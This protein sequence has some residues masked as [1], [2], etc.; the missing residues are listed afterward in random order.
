MATLTRV[1]CCFLMAVV[2][3]SFNSLIAHPESSGNTYIIPKM[4]E[5]IVYEG[6]KVS[7]CF[8]I[9]YPAG[10]TFGGPIS[11]SGTIEN[12]AGIFKKSQVDFQ[13]D[14]NNPCV[15]LKVVAFDR[16][17][18]QA[19]VFDV[20]SAK[21]KVVVQSNV[22]IIVRPIPDHRQI[23]FKNDIYIK[24][25]DT[26]IDGD[27]SDRVILANT[28]AIAPF[29][30][31]TMAAYDNS[32]I[33]AQYSSAYNM[34]YTGPDTL[35]EN[36]IM[37]I[38]IGDKE[39]QTYGNIPG[40]E[41]FFNGQDYSENFAVTNASP[42]I[43]DSG[44]FLDPNNGPFILSL[45]QG[46]F[47]ENSA[48]QINF[49]GNELFNF[50]STNLGDFSS[51][52]DPV[53][54]VNFGTG[55]DF[56]VIL[57]CDGYLYLCDLQEL[58]GDSGSWGFDAGGAGVDNFDDQT[59]IDFCDIAEPDCEEV[60]SDFSVD[61]CSLSLSIANCSILDDADV[62]LFYKASGP[63]EDETG[64]QQIGEGDIKI[65][66]TSPTTANIVAPV[67]HNVG[68]YMI[69]VICEECNLPI[70]HYLEVDE[71]CPF[72]YSTDIQ[73][74]SCNPTGGVDLEIIGVGT[75]P[76]SFEW[77]NGDTNQNLSMVDAGLYTVTVTDANQCTAII[78]AD[79][80]S[81]CCEYYLD[82]GGP[83]LEVAD[84][85][86]DG[87]WLSTN[88]NFSFP[89][90]FGG[91]NPQNITITDLLVDLSIY[92]AGS[93]GSISVQ[94][95]AIIIESCR[96]YQYIVG[97]NNP[98]KTLPC[99]NT[100]VV[101]ISNSCDI[102]VDPE[103]AVEFD[104]ISN[105]DC[106]IDVLIY[107]LQN[108]SVTLD[109]SEIGTG[110]WTAV[111]ADLTYSTQLNYAASGL[112]RL[113]G[114]GDSGCASVIGCEIEHICCECS[115]TSVSFTGDY[116]DDGEICLGID[117]VS[118]AV[119]TL[120]CIGES[121]V[122]AELPDGS[123]VTLDQ[124]ANNQYEYVDTIINDEYTGLYSFEV[125]D[126]YGCF[127]EETYNLEAENCT[128][129]NNCEMTMV[130][131]SPSPGLLSV[132][133]LY[134]GC[135]MMDSF[136]ISWYH[137]TISVD[138]KILEMGTSSDNLP[139]PL[140]NYPVPSGTMI[141]VLDWIS[142]DGV[143][144]DEVYPGI[145]DC[146]DAVQVEMPNCGQ[147]YTLS[148]NYTTTDNA[149]VAFDYNIAGE[150]NYILLTFFGY[151]INDTI[152]VS[153]NGTSVFY[154]AVGSDASPTDLNSTPKTIRLSS[155]RFMISKDSLDTDMDSLL[156]VQ[157]ISSKLNAN[158]N[159]QLIIQ[160]TDDYECG[161]IGTLDVD[162]IA[163]DY[164]SINC[165]YIVQLPRY[166]VLNPSGLPERTVR[167]S[168]PTLVVSNMLCGLQI[169]AVYDAG[170]PNCEDEITASADPAAGRFTLDFE[171]N[172]SRYTVLKDAI[173]DSI[174]SMDINC[175]SYENEEYYSYLRFSVFALSSYCNP[176]TGDGSSLSYTKNI[177]IRPCLAN[178]E[179][180]D[181]EM[182]I[183][184]IR[185]PIL[186]YQE[187]ACADCR[188]FIQSNLINYINSQIP[189]VPEWIENLHV[190]VSSGNFMF[191]D[192][193]SL[194]NMVF[195]SQFIRHTYQA[196]EICD[197]NCMQDA[198]KLVI[199]DMADG[200]NNYSLYQSTDP[201]AGL[202]DYDQLIY[203]VSNG[204]QTYAANED[205]EDYFSE[206]DLTDI[207]ENEVKDM[208]MQLH[209]NPASTVV[210]LD[211]HVSR[212]G[213]SIMTIYDS[214][215]RVV[216]QINY[217]SNAGSNREKIDIS[218]LNSGL[219][220]VKLQHGTLSMYKK[221]IVIK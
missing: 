196:A 15:E 218:D 93:G 38:V 115:I 113:S 186:N 89:Y 164:D 116:L 158:T 112:Y 87:L 217:R 106:S 118:F 75:P 86:V 160:C 121:V 42:N 102:V 64:Y 37:C 166:G 32:S 14:V 103:C 140:Y 153:H 48:G 84:I 69:E 119:T 213:T 22:T 7:V 150:S 165:R 85:K 91:N 147:Y 215:L 51:P 216:D 39:V 174:F 126:E 43:P 187:S 26:S 100:D 47:Y 41:L 44:S 98:G 96:N 220:F 176:S 50:G 161:S 206:K 179:F 141:P 111:L 132:A 95:S 83:G 18:P 40:V 198:Y 191:L 65:I 136:Q 178:F 27:G 10:S 146:F 151:T 133:N 81:C 25:L 31:F 127:G 19:F 148:Y 58:L 125:V 199:D 97:T 190:N 92:E 66:K 21:P 144:Y 30:S 3:L 182:T 6:S 8:D 122:T 129:C 2:G 123:Q 12:S 128:L 29:T 28:T 104:I 34:M 157:V 189:T 70:V 79:I 20:Q 162:E 72:S 204:I 167:R 171:D 99:E 155:Y 45:G 197:P 17:E 152:K 180:D 203:Q 49:S 33:V 62:T 205:V 124:V 173:I 4:R 142:I 149:D 143:F 110:V 138:S 210:N 76:F 168:V 181:V 107:E 56:N 88:S 52:T 11:L 105:D 90:D 1:W 131:Y 57:I 208:D 108:Y 194:S 184:L 185:I 68:C 202:N 82:F 54:D 169:Q 137:D 101:T 63:C 170:V 109:Y 24:G 53:P 134:S 175:E 159:W 35:P 130:A 200:C 192:S 207:L 71:C 23:L 80:E 46:Q 154:A 74:A 114:I 145:G 135:G 117:S 59:C 183:T 188:T 16:E 77:N 209:P 177:Y 120:G 73:D 201:C 36:G 9:E 139:M 78:S 195:G 214:D 60:L 67:Y 211:Y 193:T 172:P 94:G 61:G 212:Q 55:G 5:V 163:C 156:H 13:I 219:Y 221:V